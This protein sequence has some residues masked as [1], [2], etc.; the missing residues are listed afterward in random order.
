MGDIVAWAMTTGSPPRMPCRRSRRR[1]RA[2]GVDPVV[3]AAAMLQGDDRAV[4]HD[5]HLSRATGHRRPRARRGR[6]GRPAPRPDAQGQGRDRGRDGRVAG[7]CETAPRAGPTTSSTT[8]RWTTSPPV[9][10]FTPDGTR[11]RRRRRGRRVHLRRLL[12]SLRPRGR[13]RSSGRRR[14]P[15]PVDVQ[16]L[17]AGG[18]LFLTRPSL[19]HHVADRGELLARAGGAGAPSRTARSGWPSGRYPLTDAVR[20]YE[21]LEGRAT[22]GKARP[23]P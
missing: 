23:H 21:A 1:P 3:A 14:G 6:W 5:R 2:R 20:R 22:E 11:R 16:R 13:S 12:A 8:R 4:P 17:N 15:P 9:R 10:A 19:A 18:S 7:K